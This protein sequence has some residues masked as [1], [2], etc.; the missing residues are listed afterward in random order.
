MV[1]EA[2]DDLDSAPFVHMQRISSSLRKHLAVE[3]AQWAAKSVPASQRSQILNA[4][5]IDVIMGY[6]GFVYE[7]MER[8][9]N[10]LLFTHPARPKDFPDT[11]VWVGT[12]RYKVAISEAEV[13]LRP[14]IPVKV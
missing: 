5:F 3:W 11:P 14:E 7:L 9:P 10:I 2:L 13:R 8:H 12:A 6:P 1:H 4:Q